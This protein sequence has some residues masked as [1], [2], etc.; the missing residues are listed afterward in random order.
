MVLITNPFQELST[1]WFW[2]SL[3]CQYIPSVDTHANFHVVFVCARL[4]RDPLVQQ[5]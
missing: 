4:S 3:K 1:G 5:Q 2:I